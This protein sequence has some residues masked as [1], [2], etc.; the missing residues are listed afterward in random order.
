MC[1]IIVPLF[2]TSP[3]TSQTFVRGAEQYAT[4]LSKTLTN[5][6]T[7]AIK[8]KPNIGNCYCTLPILS[9]SRLFTVF[10]AECLSNEDVSNGYSFP[11]EDDDLSNYKGE[12][13]HLMIPST[14]LQNIFSKSPRRQL[15]RITYIA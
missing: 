13:P 6:T 12:S 5:D 1:C 14:L 15:I 11:D 7:E 8:A 10:K 4:L 3:T 2:Q 9:L